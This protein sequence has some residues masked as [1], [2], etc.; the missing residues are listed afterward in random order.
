MGGARDQALAFERNDNVR[1]RR[2]GIHIQRV[3][4]HAEL[5]YVGAHNLDVIRLRK[6]RCPSTTKLE[7]SV[8]VQVP[9]QFNWRIIRTHVGPD[10]VTPNDHAHLHT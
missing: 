2:S 6:E 5:V 1:F 3:G 10:I 9:I 7:R 8:R 4:L